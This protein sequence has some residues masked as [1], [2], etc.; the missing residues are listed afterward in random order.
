MDVTIETRPSYHVAYLRYT[1]PYGADG[2]IHELWER[3]ERWATQRGLWTKDRV[4]LGVA[5]DDPRATEPARC[6]YDAAIVVPAGF[7][8]GE[9]AIA[10]TAGGACA[11][12]R[13]VGKPHEIGPA[14]A[15]IFE[16]WLPASGYDRDGRPPYELYDA[17]FFD[18][19]T[20]D[21]TCDLCV[22][23]RRR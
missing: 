11:V 8:D 12:R 6:R 13:F 1:G 21:I 23:V 14:F 4:C 17:D 15:S 20:Y 16:E 3:L 19:R 18:V 5:R 2:G 9:I 22:P 10:D 7:V